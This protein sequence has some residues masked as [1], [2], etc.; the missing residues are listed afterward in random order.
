MRKYFN[1]FVLFLQTFSIFYPC[2]ANATTLRSFDDYVDQIYQRHHFTEEQDFESIREAL[3]DAYAT[4]LDLNSLSKEEL[5][6]LGI[7]SEDQTTSYFNHI[8]HTGLL[9]SQYELQAIPSFDLTT[10]ALLLPF[11]YVLENHST[12][13]Q[14]ICSSTSGQGNSFFLLRYTSP[15]QSTIPQKSAHV[16]SNS[17]PL[18]NLDKYTAQF[19]LQH[20]NDIVFGVTARKQAGET[21]CWDHDTHRYGFSLWSIF[22]QLNGKRY[23]KRI[24]VGDYQVGYGQ[25]LLL[26]TSYSIAKGMNVGAVICSNNTGIRPY[27]GIRRIGLRGIALTSALGATE[28]TGFY[29]TN[30][31]D[32]KTEM[33]EQCR[34]YTRRID[35]TGKYHTTNNLKKKSTIKEQ[36]VG[37]TILRKFNRNQTEIGANVVYNYYDIP[38]LTEESYATQYLFQWQ[39]SFSLFYRLLWKNVTLFG[40]HGIT[41]PD[42]VIENEKNKHGVILGLLISLSRYVDLS[43]T[44]YYYEKGFYSPYGG[45]YYAT[46][47]SNEKG[48]NA[49]IKFTPLASWQILLNWNT[50][51]TLY[52]KPKC[53]VVGS[54]NTFTTRSC[55]ALSRKTLFTLQYRLKKRPKNNPK[56]KKDELIEDEEERIKAIKNSIKF[57]VDYQI[58]PS[59]RTNIEAQYIYYAFSDQINYGYALS[60][61]QKWKIKKFQFACKI[62]CFSAKDHATRLYFHEPGP[63]Y[64]GTQFTSYYGNGLSTSFLVCWKPIPLIRL[65]LIWLD[66]CP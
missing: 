52:P 23:F 55:Y 42:T 38:I 56:T 65:E 19:L 1:F 44:G 3:Q 51:A 8:A 36:V 25:G 43:A 32:A 60:S 49:I 61:T 31:L 63:L 58:T 28:L 47:N 34:P 29:A 16:R 4:P 12:P 39:Y 40:E 46:D 33:D 24:I 35:R 11:V 59:W 45:S 13:S 9:Y 2:L 26:N 48:F 6:G 18:G 20:S 5:S 7:L 27:K 41:F 21:F 53:T 14:A 15:I 37:A 30:N 10:I 17:L 54:G 22:I 64:S 57:K 66:I 50:F 62:T